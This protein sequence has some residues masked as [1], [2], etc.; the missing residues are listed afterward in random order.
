VQKP[1]RDYIEKRNGK[2]AVLSEAGNVLGSHRTRAQALEQLRA[3]EYSKAH[4]DSPPDM[5]RLELPGADE[6]MQWLGSDIGMRGPLDAIDPNREGGNG[7]TGTLQDADPQAPG[8]IQPREEYRAPFQPGSSGPPTIGSQATVSIAGL[9]SVG[10]EN[11]AQPDE[12]SHLT[13]LDAPLDP[14]VRDEGDPNQYEMASTARLAPDLNEANEPGYGEY[15]SPAST[16]QSSPSAAW[17]D[18][19][20][21]DDWLKAIGALPDIG[22]SS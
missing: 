3:V 16:S 10:P 18:P 12:W 15:I 2:F 4:P 20:G 5:G 6:S 13:A 19:A 7:E 21:D 9:Q 1:R 14:V 22:G 8:Q 11:Q 17:R